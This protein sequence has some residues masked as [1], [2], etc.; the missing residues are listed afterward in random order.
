MEFIFGVLS[1][2]YFIFA[3][4]FAFYVPGKIVL[5]KV[6]FPKLMDTS[7]SIVVG[8]VL[9]AMQGLVF[10]Y[11]H[12]RFMSYLYILVFV[13]LFIKKKYYNSL[14][15][16]DFKKLDIMSFSLIVV[17]VIGQVF[18]YITMGIQT[19]QGVIIAAHNNED[20]IWHAALVKELIKR[21]PPNEPA[22]SGVRLEDYHYLYNL[23]TADLIRVFH[24]P[25]FSAQFWGMYFLAPIL[26]GIIGYYLAQSI[27]ASKLFTR[28][29]LFFLYFSGT[30]AGWIMLVMRHTFTWNLSSLINDASKFMDSPPYGYAIVIGLTGFYVLLQYRGAL[31]KKIIMLCALLFGCLLEFKVYVGIPF[32]IAFG[33]Y[34]VGSLVYK[35]ITPFISFFAAGLLAVILLKSGSSSSAGL[36]YLPVDIPR[37]FINQPLLGLRD[38]QLRWIIFQDHHNIPRLIQYGLYMSGLYLVIQ[39]GLQLLGLIPFPWMI[40]KLSFEKSFFL[41]AGILSSFFLGLFFYQT[42]GG[43]NIWE[44]FLASAPFLSLLTALSLTLLLQN[45]QKLLQGITLGVVVLVVI[46]QWLMSMQG[47]FQQEYQMGFHGVSSA[48]ATSFRYIA[49]KT[50]TNSV[51]LTENQPAYS[52]ASAANLFMNR[53]TYFAGNGVRQ[54]ITPEIAKRKEI[55]TLV[56]KDTENQEIVDML[57]K[58]HIGYIYYYGV[59]ANGY[60]QNNHLHIVFANQ[61]ATIFQVQ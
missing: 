10:G 5:G 16:H 48:Q 17:G 61:A 14:L 36:I 51:V 53:D 54:I 13:V 59:P 30:A 43:A 56:E 26:L 52:Y 15:G 47:Y 6:A 24:L 42:V 57:K 46:P 60:L 49:T 9:W 7:I 31:P 22:I 18:S 35:K 3:A 8:I 4:V 28:L 39:F 19:S 20:H 41:Y 38:W 29:F 27:Y 2:I 1:V 11:L 12:I 44:F 23:V 33:G 21:F 34:A 55:V 50:P 58:E 45:K 37:D 40:K 25:F 32:L